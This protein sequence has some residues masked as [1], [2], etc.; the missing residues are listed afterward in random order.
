M[1]STTTTHAHHPYEVTRHYYNDSMR[2]EQSLDVYQPISSNNSNEDED[3]DRPVIVLVMGSGWMGHA[4]WIYMGTNWWN[5]SGPQQICGTL[6]YTCISVRHG[7]AFVSQPFLVVFCSVVAAMLLQSM[8]NSVMAL[9]V[10]LLLFGWLSWQGQGAATLDDMVQDVTDALQFIQTNVN[11]DDDDDDD[12]DDSILLRRKRRRSLLGNHPTTTTT[13]IPR[14]FVLGGYSSGAHVLATF[15]SRQQQ[16]LQQSQSQHP[17]TNVVGI[18]HLSGVLSLKSNTSWAMHWYTRVVFGN[19]VCHSMPSPLGASPPPPRIR[20][21][22][23]G[24]HHEVPFGIPILDGTLCAYQYQQWLSCQGFDARCV[25]VASN[26]WSVLSSRALCRA[27]DEHLPWF[28]SSTS[29]TTSTATSTTN[30][31]TNTKMVESVSSSS[32]PGLV[33]STHSS[34]VVEE[35]D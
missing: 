21:L 17:P 12:D 28:S 13:T 27:L 4:W 23:I 20:H 25:L 18:L 5:A 33:I 30:T 6:G 29:T 22:V 10:S 7:G 1:K 11:D 32:V 31:N 35:D 34:S 24:C 8:D 26:H 2:V 9:V 3:D 19:R 15:L 16:Q 14:T